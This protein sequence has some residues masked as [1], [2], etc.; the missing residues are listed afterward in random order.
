MF[1]FWK[2]FAAA[3]FFCSLGLINPYCFD[4]LL[5][6][7]EGWIRTKYFSYCLYSERFLAAEKVNQKRQK[8]TE[9][10]HT[11]SRNLLFQFFKPFLDSKSLLIDLLLICSK[12]LYIPWLDAIW[13]QIW[14]SYGYN[15]FPYY[16]IYQNF[17]PS[18][19]Q[20]SKLSRSTVIDNNVLKK[21]Q[22]SK[23]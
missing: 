17:Q 10:C 18:P 21:L 9:G 16:K 15:F 23:L 20:T 5:F 11:L 7:A 4:I 22:Y 2:K 8:L 13:R 12:L 19:E 14:T 1:F 3:A 6:N